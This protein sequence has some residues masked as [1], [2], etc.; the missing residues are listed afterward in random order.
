MPLKAGVGPAETPALAG[1]AHLQRPEVEGG[2]GRRLAYL[3]GGRHL[4]QRGA[5]GQIPPQMER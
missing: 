3:E 2:D 1:E 5:G 4:S